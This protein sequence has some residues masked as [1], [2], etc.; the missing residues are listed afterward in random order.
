MNVFDLDR[1]LV[2]DYERFARS[3]TQIRAADIRVQVENLYASNRFWPDPLISINP[4]FERGASIDRLAADGTVHGDTARVFCVEG[5]YIRLYRHQEQAVAKTAERQSFV[6]TT[7]TGSGKSLCFF[8][9]IIDS[10]IRARA[11]GEAPRTRAIVIYPMNALANSQLSE[12]EKFID[13]SELSE[14]LRPTF[15]R[16]T[17]QESDDERKRIRDAK[18]DILLTNFMMLELL[19][20]RQNPLDRAVIANAD[21]LEFIVLDELHTYRGRQGADVAM[22]MRRVRDRLCRERQPICI[23]TSATMA[24]E[25][26]QTARADAVASVASRLFGQDINADAVIDESLERATNPL[27]KPATLGDRLGA[28]VDAEI[29]DFIDDA[30]LRE[31]PLAVWIE[32]EIGLDDSQRLTRRRPITIAEA[33]KRLAAQTRRDETRCQSQLQGMLI[34]MSRPANERG[35][36]GDRAFLAFKL[37][38]FLSGAGHVYATLRSIPQRRVTLDGQRF[39]PDDPEAR[40]YA[41][42]FCR[43]CGQ[44]HHPVVL[45]DASGETRVLPRDIDEIPLDDA[46]SRDQAG[47]LMPEPEND[48]EYSFSGAPEDYPEEWTE[49]ARDGSLRLRSNRRAAALQRLIVNA[50]GIVGTGGRAAWFSPGKFRFCPACGHQPPAQA[51]EINKLAS[52]SAEGRSSATTLLVSSAVRWMNRHGKDLPAERRKLLG[53]TDNRQ[54][55]ALQAGHFNDFIFVSLLRAATLAAIRTAGPE[56]LSDDEFGRRVQAALGFTASHRAR[57]QEWML[58]PDVKGAAQHDAERSLSRV[59]AHRIWADQRRGWRFTNPSLEELGLVRA[60]Y[61]SLD[62]LAADDGAFANAAPEL[63]TATPETRTKALGILLDHLRRGLAVTTDAL[64]PANVEVVANA[65]RQSLREPWSISQQE[66]PR[67]AAALMIDAPQRAEAGLRGEPLIVRGGPRSRLARELGGASIWGKRLNA[68]TYLE[69][70]AGLIAAAAQYQLVRSVS[71][72]FD[73]DG[74]RLAANAVRLVAADGRAGGRPANSF[75][76]NLYQTLADTLAKGGDALFGLD[77]REHTAQ[78]DQARR[79]WREWRFRWG[80]DDRGK[81]AEKKEELRQAG[82]PNVFLPVMFCSPT[83]ELGVDISALNAV[84]MRNMPPTPAN[85]AQRSGRAGR[86]GQAALVVTYCAAQSPHDQVLTTRMRRLTLAQAVIAFFFN[87]VLLAPV[88]A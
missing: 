60:E 85:Y 75:F 42:F 66:T 19:V 62:E 15:A 81:L 63:R 71:T 4:H 24:S 78:V 67:I 65:A 58:D 12:L 28:A 14:Q 17:G 6:V 36:A 3:F 77:G 20:T 48:D 45:V 8:I 55:A 86:S 83:M 25:G 84:Y 73:V 72:N 82:E 1:A 54:D 43:A 34:L 74:W 39:D 80:K 40:L 59:L 16:Y 26:S 33:A 10:A 2:S 35:S 52:L 88:A 38:Q 44:E 51:R 70:V 46:E 76:V 68:K 56:G 31:H 29:P 5:Q 37:H 53:F 64:D 11:A 79:E 21:G 13:Q 7:G 32:L 47:Y 30:A 23:G 61:V 18:P 57:R 49:A 41:T 69:V 50:A 22:L 9:P 27:L 87:T